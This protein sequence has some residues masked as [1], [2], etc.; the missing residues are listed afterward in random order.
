MSKKGI[1]SLVLS[2][3]MVLTF[4]TPSFAADQS[5]VEGT[6]YS[7]AVE[8]LSSL[9]IMTGYD[10]GTFKPDNN[11]TRAEFA[12]M[13]V[14]ALGL[15]STAKSSNGTTQ[16]KDV[17][18]GQWF[19]GYI[20]IAAAKGIVKGYGDG[21]F[22]PNSNVTYG[23]AITMLVRVLGYEPAVEGTNWPS[24]Y[25]VKAAEIG[26][27]GNL[28]F[29]AK[30]AANRGD[31]A[32]LLNNS[33][34]V[35]IM[36]QVGYGTDMTWEEQEDET[37]LTEFLNVHELEEAVIS[38]TVG[39]S[40]GKLDKDEVEIYYPETDKKYIFK[41]KEGLNLE[42]LLGHEVTV[43]VDDEDK[44]GKIEDD[45]T[46]I[47]AWNTT[48]ERDIIAWDWIDD[49]STKDDWDLSDEDNKIKVTLDATDD[50]F[51]LSTDAVVYYNFE[52]VTDLSNL[53]SDKV[54]VGYAYLWE[55]AG[56]VILDDDD[57]IIFINM[58][59]LDDP[60]VITKVNVDDEKVTYFKTSE[61]ESTLKLDGE[62][63]T[64]Y[65]N[66]EVTDLEA[67]DS[68][69][70]LYFWELTDGSYVL[71]A[72]D[73]KITGTLETFYADDNRYWDY[74]LVVDGKTIY[75]G[76]NF[77]LS[78]DEN[79]T[80]DLLG[81]PYES[82]DNDR[83]TDLEDM[84]G[85]TVTVYLGKYQ[86]ATD[87]WNYG[88]HIVTD[89][90]ST[91][92][93]VFVVTDAPWSSKTA[94]TMYYVEL[95]NANDNEVVYELTEEDT[96]VNG[97]TDKD[98]S[99][100]TDVQ[101]A[102]L[103]PAGTM[104]EVDFNSDGTI[105]SINTLTSALNYV[106][107][108]GGLTG[109]NVDDD[110]DRVK[111]N[112]VWYYVEDTTSFFVVYRDTLNNIIDI[113]AT[114]WSSVSDISGS[115]TFDAIAKVDDK[116]LEALLIDNYT[117]T[118]V[119]SKDFGYVLARIVKSDGLY[120]RL[121]VEDQVIEYYAGDLSADK[122]AQLLEGT[123]IDFKASGRTLDSVELFDGKVAVPKTSLSLSNPDEISV[124]AIDKATVTEEVYGSVTKVSVSGGY[125][126]SVDTDNDDVADTL[127]GTYT[128]EDNKFVAEAGF[129]VNFAWT[130]FEIVSGGVDVRNG[131]IEVIPFGGDE[132]IDAAFFVDV[133]KYGDD[134]FFYDTDVSHLAD[135][136]KKVLSLSD[137]TDGD[138]VVIYN[139]YDSAIV[140]YVIVVDR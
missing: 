77:T 85:H 117:G 119:G 57:N 101:L 42:S 8:R 76:P 92:E 108:E 39:F 87:G 68:D 40:Q 82:V 28:E 67:L 84:V 100:L 5:D 4:A 37:I 49:M 1:M 6:K 94:G 122:R 73:G 10:D 61:K 90:D 2:L 111:V 128:T 36:E 25:L 126:F 110:Y 140:E 132:D 96:E 48:D 89:V 83:L 80:V 34:D 35:D 52:K 51:D 138:I 12:A 3:V 9:G 70:V 65:K 131:V 107:S 88:R 30:G 62:E 43:F 105:S 29:D 71:S 98:L 97:E 115:E 69:D 66:G 124:G 102:A 91:N 14:R 114:D 21:T 11:I 38:Q 26:I 53:A 134:S 81:K 63:Y 58:V 20:N 31:V 93:E 139:V 129:D 74:S 55:V 17:A 47:L 135:A 64:I 95:I 116:E 50:T 113:E 27:L 23:E 16:F 125:E 18:A 32:I 104:V 56:T 136:S 22:N 41:V 78:L 33:L 24:N 60:V 120:V 103:L 46:V 44:D 133:D 130:K 109:N 54:G 15:E 106:E 59:N 127:V 99:L 118:T 13:A 86:E 7:Q 75:V 121:A 72:F 137:L 45:E 123:L 19:T 112:G 79:D